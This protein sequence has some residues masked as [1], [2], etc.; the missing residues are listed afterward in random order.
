MKLKLHEFGE[1]RLVELVRRICR[2]GKGVVVGIG[3]DA[4]AV[5]MDGQC[6]VATTDMLVSKQHFPPGTSPEQMGRK[7]V[8]VNL[9]D[10]AAM[11]ASPLGLLFSVGLPRDLDVGFVER[12]VRGMDRAARE[13]GTS[14]VG[15]DIDE[16]DEIVIAGAAFGSCRRERLM[17]RSGARPGDILA[18]TGSLGAASAGLSILLGKKPAGGYR[19]L[20][21]AQLDPVPR[22][23]EGIA[24]AGTGAVTSAIDITDSL[25]SNLWQIARESGVRIVLEADKLPVHPLVLKYAEDA[26]MDPME[27]ALFGGEDLELL[28]TLRPDRIDRAF[29]ALRRIGT[30]LTPIGRVERGRGALVEKSGRIMRLP[31]RGY[32]H[33]R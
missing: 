15:G 12:I 27:F 13:Y 28:L 10:L 29:R 5:E 31:D 17:R 8:A 7:A 30:A 32:E 24:L 33:F 14:V 3:D 25:A 23:R 1:R 9:S 4:A 22:V 2:P 11:G 18:V 26:G 19:A 16:S 21:K 6:I 20:T